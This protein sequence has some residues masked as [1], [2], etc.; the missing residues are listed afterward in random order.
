MQT[1]ANMDSTLDR[2]KHTLTEEIYL[3]NL[4][5]HK[6]QQD[7]QLSYNHVTT[8]IHRFCEMLEDSLLEDLGYKLKLT[9]NKTDIMNKALESNWVHDVV[10]PATPLEIAQDLAYT[11]HIRAYDNLA[12][13]DIETDSLE[14]ESGNILQVAIVTP[15]SNGL[16]HKWSSYIRPPSYSDTSDNK[17]YHI[18]GIDWDMLVK[19]PDP[20]TVLEEV[21]L[22]LQGK[23]VIGY[24]SH[25]FDLP[26]L[27]HHCMLHGINLELT[28]S[29]DLYPATW[30]HRRNRLKDALDLFKIPIVKP[31]DALYDSIPLV[32][33]FNKLVEE[34]TLPPNLSEL[35][36]YTDGEW[37]NIP[38]LEDHTWSQGLPTPPNTQELKRKCV[39]IDN[40]S[41]KRFKY[42]N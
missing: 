5:K 18:N 1:T 34:G 7:T 14:P 8:C 6:M 2:L 22:R 41:S 27:K 35:T 29:L 40:S 42:M 19:A 21:S 31:H 25:K 16:L 33:L 38:I 24:N 23:M 3:S 13:I 37:K 11:S 10:Q 20:Y 39:E 4:S 17:A 15:S 9:V 36:E 28:Y 32:G 30:L 26:W 12:F